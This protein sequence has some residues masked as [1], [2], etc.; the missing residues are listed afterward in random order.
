MEEQHRQASYEL[1]K[2]KHLSNE[3]YRKWNS[4]AYKYNPSKHRYEFDKKLGRSNDVPKYIKERWNVMEEKLLQIFKLAEKLNTNTSKVYAEI[5][6]TANNSHRLEIAIRSKKDYS[7]IERCDITTQETSE[8]KWDNI[9]A[10]LET[11][12]GGVKHE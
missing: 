12:I 5:Q 1:S 9:I 11:F 3:N 4:S 7:Y 8:I 10:L 2:S 6:Y